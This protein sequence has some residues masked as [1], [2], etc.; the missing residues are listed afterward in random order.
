M[1]PFHILQLCNQLQRM[2]ARQLKFIEDTEVFQTSLVNFLSFQFPEV[3]AFF[4]V[5]PTAT[6]P[7]NESAAAHPYAAADPSAGIDKTETVHYSSNTASDVFDWHT[8]FEHQQSPK[9]QPDNPESS[10][11]HKQKAEVEAKLGEKSPPKAPANDPDLSTRRKG[12]APTGRILTKEQP[13]SPVTA[14]SE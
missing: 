2:E 8:P 9:A 3:V 11:T 10:H 1:P 6:S 4:S 12:K 5:H 14:H 13:S 7:L